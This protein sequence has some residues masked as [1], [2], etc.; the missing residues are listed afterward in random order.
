MP[1]KSKK[2]GDKAWTLSSQRQTSSRN[3]GQY[4]HSVIGL[5]GALRSPQ[6]LVA[7]TSTSTSLPSPVKQGVGNLQSPSKFTL[8]SPQKGPN[9]STATDDSG[10]IYT[11]AYQLETDDGTTTLFLPENLEFNQQLSLPARLPEGF[12]SKLPKVDT[13]AT[14][15][16]P[17]RITKAKLIAINK[18]K[19]EFGKQHGNN[20]YYKN[21]DIT[22]ESANELLVTTEIITDQN[23]GQWLD[24]VPLSVWSTDKKDW[25][26]KTKRL[27]NLGLGT[28]YSNAAM[29][30]INPLITQLLMTNDPN[31]PTELELT[32]AP[33]WVLGFENIRLLQDVTYVL[34]D[35]STPESTRTVEIM[36]PMLSLEKIPENIIQFY[37][38]YFFHLFNGKSEIQAVCLASPQKHTAHTQPDD[39]EVETILKR[40]PQRLIFSDYEDDSSESSVNDNKA[41]NAELTTPP[42]AAKRPRN[43]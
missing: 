10:T 11:P 15:I 31:S 5:M 23:L 8:S 12:A 42:P 22:N 33:S 40:K 21:K 2:N 37:K 41:D 24:L 39:D 26:D 25:Q 36:F 38:E 16:P 9:S 7:M 27:N 4:S 35:I 17:V 28:K 29:E 30:L 3:P 18:L 20:R 19:A 6:K 14:Q 1:G 34:R 13:L 43:G 32:V